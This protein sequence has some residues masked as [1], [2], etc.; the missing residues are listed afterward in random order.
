MTEDIVYFHD[1]G[2]NS[3]S[4]HI[5]M[6]GISRCDGSYTVQRRNSNLYAIEYIIEGRG[7]LD[8]DGHTFQPQ[9]GDVYILHRGSD[10]YYKS[11]RDDPWTKVWVAFYGSLADTL[12]ATYNLA[13]IFLIHDCTIEDELHNIFSAAKNHLHAQRFHQESAFMVHDLIYKL[14]SVVNPFNRDF[15]PVEQ[16]V[17]FMQLNIHRMIDLSTICKHAGR[18]AS[19]LNRYFKVKTGRTVYDYFIYMKI[20]RAKE[21][22]TTSSYSIKQIALNLGFYDEFHFSKCF[23]ERT[24]FSPRKFRDTA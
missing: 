15:D 21:L 10:H 5:D 24:G 2:T 12:F 13:N 1:T 23:K 14:Y 7:T 22:L 16:A 4:F 8:I 9:R 6:V 19:Q 20:Q 11:C 17:A 3:S 18:S